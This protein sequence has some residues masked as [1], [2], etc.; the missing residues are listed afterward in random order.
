MRAAIVTRE[1]PPEVYGGA[2]VHVEYLVRSLVRHVAVDVHCF[3]KPRAAAEVRR[4]YEPW[5]ELDGS[6]P[7]LAALRTL[8]VDL[9]A[10]RHV[11]GVDLV[12]THTWYANFAGHLAK[13]AYGIPHVMTSHSL[14]PL[15]PWKVEQLGGGYAISS[16]CERTSIEAADA[17]IAVSE[18]MKADI[19]RAY[20]TVSPSRVHV[21]HNGIEPDE[22]RPDPGTDVLTKH[23]IDPARPYAVFVGRVT[24]QKGIVH[25][26]R[27]FRHVDPKLSLV[28]CAGEPDTPEIG[29]E[30][31]A[32]SAEIQ[33]ER[34]GLVLV[35][36]MLSRPDVVQILSHARVFVCPSV[37]EPFGIVNLEAMACGVPVVA[38]AVGGIPEIVVEG[39]TG[40][41]V[42]FDGDG[43]PKNEP[44]DPEVFA[45]ELARA[46]NELGTDAERAR[47]FGE[48]GR[49]R[50]V[51][52]FSWSAIAERTAALYRT[53]VKA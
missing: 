40:T 42:R 3:G 29:A 11:R 17:V 28:L 48:A 18:A 5:A 32:L 27:A 12:H 41:L 16:F 21:I 14:E 34:G 1:Y 44:R 31:R 47:R 53:L 37:Y 4:T 23:G 36:G 39:K 26:L 33:A 7:E 8:S 13:L 52:R 50:V 24:R 51:D 38:S 6:E 45:R 15:R 19:L 20:P 30:F 49:A 46:V 10:A 43:T 22:Y 9:L 25:L 2:G 35:E